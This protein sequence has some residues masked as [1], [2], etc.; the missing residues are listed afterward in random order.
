MDDH[1]A[2]INP[3]VLAHPVL[4][5]VEYDFQAK[6][7]VH[8]NVYLEASLPVQLGALLEYLRRQDPLAVM[9]RIRVAVTVEVR[10][11]H[12]HQLSFLC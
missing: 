8:V 6:V 11:F 9:Q 5:R 2:V 1:R 12:L 3:R 4:N 7:T 10:V